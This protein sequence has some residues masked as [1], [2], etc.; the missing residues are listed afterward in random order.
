[1]KLKENQLSLFS[2]YSLVLIF[3]LVT[4]CASAQAQSSIP[5]N[6]YYTY[7]K[8]STGNLSAE[9]ALK[10]VGSHFQKWSYET[11][12]NQGITQSVYWFYLPIQSNKNET[13]KVI[14][15]L[16]NRVNEA[17]LYEVDSEGK[18][19]FHSKTNSYIPIGQRSFPL[20][21]IS[22]PIQLE[23]R[24]VKN[25][26]LRIDN[27]GVELNVPISVMSA[28]ETLRTEQNRHWSYG[29]YFGMFLFIIIFNFFL[30]FSLR[31]K[32][33]LWYNAYVLSA[34]LFMV[35][36]EKFYVEMYPNFFLRYFENA[37]VPPFSLLLMGTSI[38]VMQLFIK[39]EKGNSKYFTFNRLLMIACFAVSGALL[40][41]SFIEQTK[42]AVVVHGLYMVTNILTALVII[43]ILISVYERR[44]ENLAIYYLIAVVLMIV[45]CVN[46]YFNH[47]GLT[48]I[49]ILQPS[50]VVVG[51]AFELTVLSLLL[52]VR[53]NNLKR[54]KETAIILAQ[55]SERKRVAQD[56]HDDLGGTLT[57]LKFLITSS[58]HEKENSAAIQSKVLSLL[59][60]AVEDVRAI[61]LDLMPRDFNE[62]GLASVLKDRI[63]QLSINKSICFSTD[64]R[65]DENLISKE[66]QLYIFRIINE[67]LNNIVRHSQATEVSLQIQINKSNTNIH[68]EDNGIGIAKNTTTSGIGLNNIRSRIKYLSGTIHI[69]TGKNGTTI[70][71]E[72]P[73]RS[74]L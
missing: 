16:G 37:W 25:I 12:F 30:Y 45:G 56:L 69:D 48:D 44:K 1:V 57:G 74:P 64:I 4:F 10:L 70:L 73:Q 46:Y 19:I 65:G 31:D 23:A 24:S 50:G 52:T 49:H 62:L 18:P 61:S 32:I 40:L 17:T 47:M 63:S 13:E 2:R 68:L 22:F 15:K 11:A 71:I 5:L 58:Y 51:L 7:L 6:S 72:V 38:R 42:V 41:L 21:H 55:E 28:D 39:Q 67:L 53:Y 29:I 60:K 20:R 3:T 33:H 36:D 26:L 34:I 14:L 27:R 66:R 9:G 54:E 35:Q 8:D 43:F 59:D